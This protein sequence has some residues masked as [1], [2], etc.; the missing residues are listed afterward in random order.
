MRHANNWRAEIFSPP[1]LFDAAGLAPRPTITSAPGSV[2]LGETFFV[3]TFEKDLI[4]LG[5]NKRYK[6]ELDGGLTEEDWV[7][8]ERLAK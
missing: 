7:R 6:F 3:E 2:T 8:Y 4:G 1:Y 5:K